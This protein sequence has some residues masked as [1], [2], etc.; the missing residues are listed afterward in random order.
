MRGAPSSIRTGTEDD[1]HSHAQR[2]L[3]ANQG[4]RMKQSFGSDFMLKMSETA[5]AHHGHG[6]SRSAAL[7][8]A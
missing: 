6:V 8:D 7:P 4:I 5:A 2:P 1:F 3:V